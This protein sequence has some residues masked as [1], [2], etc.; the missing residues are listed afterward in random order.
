M[1]EVVER[2]VKELVSHGNVRLDVDADLA[3][4]IKE[5]G[6]LVPLIV[7]QQA[8]KWVIQDGH[9]R[10]NGAVVA[11]LET[12]PTIEKEPPVDGAAKISEQYILNEQRKGL[13]Q[14]D[15]AQVYQ[16]LKEEYGLPQK[17]IAL[18][19]GVS[20]AEVSLALAALQLHPT[21]RDAMLEGKIS[22]S[23]IEPVLSLSQEHQGE[24]AP[25]VIQKKTVK[26]VSE[27]V[28]AYR[29][30]NGL[31]RGIRTPR[32]T[33]QD[34]KP[35]TDPMEAMAVD[36]LRVALG[37]VKLA[38]GAIIASPD[39]RSRAAVLAGEILQLVSKIQ[40]GAQTSAGYDQVDDLEE[41]NWD[42]LEV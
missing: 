19:L 30:A 36:A 1:A 17:E 16:R 3:P 18:Q 38:A 6:V 25:L 42:E 33:E 5:K 24:I 29:L 37:N 28:K 10:F 12:V 2:S 27:A 34:Q 20:E 41:I 8:G 35:V 4:S 14:L 7:Y 23:A 26:A 21:L 11:G 39:L 13:N 31:E 40:A 15:K 9:R 22:H 32:V